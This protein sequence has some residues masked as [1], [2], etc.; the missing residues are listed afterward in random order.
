MIT[1]EKSKI[2]LQADEIDHL[3]IRYTDHHEPLNKEKA[4][5]FI[6]MYAAWYDEVKAA[7]EGTDLDS[8]LMKKDEELLS[9]LVT[10]RNTL[11]NM[12]F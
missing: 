5:R 1:V 10:V 12:V 3:T 7:L 9:L 11:L 4:V 8:L 6:K 2:Y